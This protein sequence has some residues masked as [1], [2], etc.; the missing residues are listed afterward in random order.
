MC[1]FCSA[2]NDQFCVEG[3]MVGRYIDGGYAEYVAVPERNVVHLPEEIPFEH[4]AILMCS[5][6]TALHALRKS[7]LKGGETVAVF[8]VGGLGISAIQLAGAFGA[9]EVYA[10]DINADK[11]KLAEKYGAVPVNASSSDPVAEIRK[12]TNGRGV[13]VALEMIGLPQTMKQAVQSLAV[14]GRAVV[15]GISDRPVE[16][17]TYR[18]LLGREAEI[19]GT[20]D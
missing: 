6:A 13:D 3:S 5:S 16:I 11:L 19:I 2:V 14:M 10:I 20:N 17:D 15:A 4:G 7:R 8:G 9:L 18:E 1:Y 12:L